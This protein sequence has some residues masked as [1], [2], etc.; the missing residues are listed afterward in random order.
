MLGRV[1]DHAGIAVLGGVHPQMLPPLEAAEVVSSVRRRLRRKAKVPVERLHSEAAER[2]LIS[3][4]EMEIA[5]MVERA[6]RQPEL[7][8]TDGD[9]WLFTADHF[10]VESGRRAELESRLA[11]IRDLKAPETGD[12]DDAWTF[13]RQGSDTILGTVRLA[14]T[15]LRL[16][17][18]SIARADRLRARLEAACGGLLSHR[19]REHSSPFAPPG[20]ARAPGK[21]PRRDEIPQEETDR[22]VRE[23]LDRHYADWPDHPLPALGGQTPRQAVRT[24]EG[25]ERVRVLIKSFEHHAARGPAGQAPD[26]ARLRRELGLLA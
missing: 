12:Q 5:M 20:P 23:M 2:Y 26:T 21:V 14:K 6:S 4:W 22:I 24:A 25:R 15:G 8:N 18:N 16:E 19:A 3:R 9:E 10:G 17:T 13:F 7:R 1:V 11:T